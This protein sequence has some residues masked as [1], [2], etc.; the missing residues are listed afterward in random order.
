MTR[1]RLWLSDAVYHELAIGD[2]PANALVRAILMALLQAYANFAS[3]RLIDY[4]VRILSTDS[5]TS[6]IRAI[7]CL[8]IEFAD[9]NGN[10]WRIVRLTKNII[11][12]SVIK[13][14]DG[15][16]WKLMNSKVVI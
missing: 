8:L 4:K 11:D 9:E 7:T 3:V 2:G 15:I 16:N 14:T 1:E 5:E 12:A 13:L 10:Y 6:G